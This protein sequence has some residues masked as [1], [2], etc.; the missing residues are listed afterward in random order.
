[1]ARHG[2]AGLTID[3]KVW[4]AVVNRKAS[5]PVSGDERIL[6]GEQLLPTQTMFGSKTAALAFASRTAWVFM[7]PLPQD[8]D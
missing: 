6:V 8:S 3:E 7:H 4:D 2:L 5:L 1:M